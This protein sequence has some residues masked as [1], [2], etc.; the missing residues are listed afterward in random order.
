MLINKGSHFQRP[1]RGHEFLLYKL[2]ERYGQFKNR[3]TLLQCCFLWSE[4]DPR[5]PTLFSER[6]PSL[7]PASK[8]GKRP[9][10]RFCRELGAKTRV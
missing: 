4:K 3:A 9:W 6:F 1:S 8:P 2:D 7:R 10:E 5:S